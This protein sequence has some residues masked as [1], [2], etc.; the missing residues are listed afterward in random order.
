VK[1]VLITGGFGFVGSHLVRHLRSTGYEA[2]VMEHPA[3]KVPACLADVQVLRADIAD[4]ASMARAKLTGL[5]A[6]LHL[7]AQSSGPRSF[8]VPVLD[9]K[10]NILGTV[11]VINWCIDNQVDRLIFASSFVVYGDQANR[12]EL[13]ETVPCRPKSV[14]ATSKLACEHLLANY[15]QPKGIRWNALRMFNVYGPGQDIT[16]PDQGV[17]GI[18]MN[19]LLHSDLA[20]VKGR[21]DRFRDLIYIEDVVQGWERCLGHDA[22]NQVFNLGTGEKTTFEGLIRSLATV[23]GK[24]DSVRIEELAGTPGDMMGCVADLARIRQALGYAPAIQLTEGL[25]QM[26]QWVQSS[27]QA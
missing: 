18:F 2:V 14:Y 13:D 25:R 12:E 27:R 26:W 10:L 6:V 24:G 8:S 17:V 7:A 19:M 9:V 4:D 3:A 21:L 15:A 22:H 1:K 20:Q 5:D 16:K 23:M 11:N